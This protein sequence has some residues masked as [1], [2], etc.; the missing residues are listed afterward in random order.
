MGLDWHSVIKATIEYH[1][2][3]IRRYYA[4]E[5]ENGE[6][7]EDLIKKYAPN[8]MKPC[9]KVGAQRMRD[10]PDFDKR[11]EDEL[12]RWKEKAAKE[13]ERGE[14]C[15]SRFVDFWEKM[16]VE[17]LKKLDGDKWFCDTCP[18]LA[19]LNGADATGNMF[20]GITV[21]SCDFRGKRISADEVL[22]ESLRE[23]A[24]E[25]HDIEGMLEYA[26][27]LEEELTRLRGGPAL[28]KQSYQDYSKEFD[29]DI[30]MQITKEPKLTEEE[31]EKIT[32]WREENLL[33]AIH[34]LRTCANNGIEMRT[35]Y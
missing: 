16:T 14:D 2:E 25:E 1:E 21:E 18:F 13:K 34:W 23:E 28:E 9:S 12:A 11:I 35:S 15:D 30:W 5:L 29:E 27:R 33:Q 10:L 7:L 31:Y 24:Y 17:E 26:D 19:Q 20:I 6:D 8:V 22:S 3:Y 32:H 4:E